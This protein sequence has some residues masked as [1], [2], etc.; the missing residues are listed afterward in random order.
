MYSYV[1]LMVWS[2]CET[3]WIVQLVIF[4]PK[5]IIIDYYDCYYC[6]SNY[7]IVLKWLGRGWVVLS[8]L[9]KGIS[10]LLCSDLSNYSEVSVGS[11]S[12]C[13]L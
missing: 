10:L 8:H 3:I 4:P 9:K 2:L 12:P 7:L 13:F 1:F 6:Y 11:L 5:I